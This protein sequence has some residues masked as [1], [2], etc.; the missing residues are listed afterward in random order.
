M[1][2]EP[3]RAIHRGPQR[4]GAECAAERWSWR[5]TSQGAHLCDWLLV[6]SSF[7]RHLA[8]TFLPRIISVGDVNLNLIHFLRGGGREF[9][10]MFRLIKILKNEV[11]CRNFCDAFS[12]V[13]D[14][15]LILLINETKEGVTWPANQAQLGFTWATVPPI[16]CQLRALECFNRPESHRGDLCRRGPDLFKV[17]WL[18]DLRAHGL[19]N[20]MC[21]VLMSVLELFALAGIQVDL[22]S[23]RWPQR[24]S[25]P[26]WKQR[27]SITRHVGNEWKSAALF[28]SPS[29]NWEGNWRVQN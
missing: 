29:F 22:N 16:T 26:E 10:L 13:A 5:W 25:H 24:C 27:T 6:T 4:I 1:M 23:G 9:K 11:V 17:T 18:V 15:N 21:R 14:L 8:D 28:S 3:E 12:P 2:D 19:L 7:S 20:G